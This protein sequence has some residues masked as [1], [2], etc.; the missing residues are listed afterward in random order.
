MCNHEDDV[1]PPPRES[2]CDEQPLVQP[3]ASGPIATQNEQ[4]TVPVQNADAD[5]P[6]AGLPGLSQS[7]EPE[8]HAPTTTTRNSSCQTTNTFYGLSV[9]DVSSEKNMTSFISFFFFKKFL[10]LLD[11]DI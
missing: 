8:I 11:S 2:S 3:G 1:L 7:N 6:Q 5:K 10:I 9:I 4:H